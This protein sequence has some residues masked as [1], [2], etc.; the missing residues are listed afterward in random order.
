MKRWILRNT[1]F[2]NVYF[3][4]QILRINIPKMEQV[5]A[6]AFSVIYLH[7]KWTENVCEL[8]K[9]PTCFQLQWQ[10][11]SHRVLF[12]HLSAA[13]LLILC[14]ITFFPNFFEFGVTIKV[15]DRNSKRLNINRFL[16]YGKSC[17]FRSH[18]NRAE[19]CCIFGN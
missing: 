11:Y 15:F 3:S 9:R 4:Q 7:N 12:A 18:E 17:S 6:A 2:I 16:Q 13:Y 19:V 10:I 1:I 14:A 5:K 8:K